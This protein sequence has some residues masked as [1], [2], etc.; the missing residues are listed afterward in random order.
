VALAFSTTYNQTALDK[1][2]LK[3]PQKWDEVLSFCKS[4]RSKGLV[5]YALGAQT[6]SQTQMPAMAMGSTVIDRDM[7]WTEQR[8]AGKT[9]FAT[10]GWLTVFEKFQEMNKSGCFVQALGASE[11]IARSLLASGKALGFF[12]PS[13]AF[14]IIQDMT[15][16]K[17]V[18]TT[19]P[20]TNNPE[21]TLLCVGLGSG[22]SVYSKTKYPAQAK[23]FL[24]FMMQPENT[25]AY[26]TATGQVPALPNDSFTASDSATSLIVKAQAEKR[27]APLT[28]QMWPNPTIVPAQRTATQQMLGGSA[29]P[30]DVAKVMDRAWDQ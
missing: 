18:F 30:V 10:S 19:F 25:N 5:P 26:A 2:G 12:G 21:E 28:N 29:S 1:S 11:E 17:L 13:S 9:A 6:G 14:K 4:A 15:Q 7:A 24:D 27:T 16:D 22:L 3:V 8:T 23:M 20:A